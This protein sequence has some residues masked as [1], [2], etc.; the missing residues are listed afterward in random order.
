MS[1]VFLAGCSG[2]SGESVK[3]NIDLSTSPDVGLVLNGPPPETADVQRFRVNLWERVAPDDRCGQCHGAGGQSPTF[4]RNDDINLAYEQA[5]PVVNLLQ[6]G[7]SRLVTKVL[8]GHNCWL[9]S[10]QACADIITVWIGDWAGE[11]GSANQVELRAPPLVEPGASKSFPVDSS[12]FASTIHPLLTL[13]C[14]ACHVDTA[15]NPQSPFFAVA[16]VN[17]A[18]DA[19]RSKIS[20]D[21]PGNSRLVLR[22]NREFHNCWTDCGTNGVEMQSAIEAF[23]ADIP[24]TVLDPALINSKALRFIDG[25]VA[26]GGGRSEVNVIAL[27]EFKTLAGFTAFDTSGVEP[28]LNL[29][30]TGNVDWVGGWGISIGDAGRAQGT[31][32]SSVKLHDLIRATGEYSIEA[33]VIPENVT[34][35]EARIISYSASNS[36]RNFS[37]DQTRYNYDFLARSSVVDANGSPALST[38]DADEVLQATLQHVVATFD[39]TNGRQIYVN[40]VRIDLIDTTGGNISDW[41]DSFAFVLGNEVSGDRLW[42]GILKFLAIHNRALNPGQVLQN[43]DAGVGEKF[44]MLFGISHLIDVNDAFVIFE[45]SQFDNFSYL[46]SQ[47][48][49]IS[50]D[51]TEAPSNIALKGIRIGIN[52][53]VPEVG[54]AYQNIDLVLNEADYSSLTGQPL[55]AVGTVL[56]IEKGFSADEFFL[57]FERLGENSNVVVE[58]IPDPRPGPVAGEPVPDIGIKTFDEINASM[59]QV[60]GVAMSQPDIVQTFGTIRQQ[61]PAVTNIEGFLSSQQMAVTQLAIEYC[62]VLMEDQGL[63]ANLFPAFDFQLP[64]GEAFDTAGRDALLQPLLDKL[65]GI[66][67]DSQPDRTLSD[68]ELHALVTTL[69]G[70]GGDVERT[71]TVAKATCAAVLGSAVLL[72]Q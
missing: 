51:A 28:A 59:A 68:A 2:G 54:Q 65:L 38:P 57:T 32:S 3:Q 46:F 1:I 33:W 12:S 10:D 34:Q 22:L 53:R 45:V 7:Q 14:S 37:L 61:L 25:T 20:I 4:A 36:L 40:G 30:F 35:E 29:G 26:S 31:T 6:P 15:D 48:Y 67:V 41:D 42:R 16:D 52:G 56:G 69:A 66:D 70:A 58:A 11:T 21:D 62:S 18:Y 27:Y 72:V 39:P 47:P 19:V 24:E 49:F 43:F 63:R 23:I 17:S 50:L 71:R 55:A 44:F 13:Y 64:P 9:G 8:S 60:T 5:N